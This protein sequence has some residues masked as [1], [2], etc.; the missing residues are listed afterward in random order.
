MFVGPVTRHDVRILRK[1]NF[2]CDLRLLG[3]TEFK[4]RMARD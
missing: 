4:L 2:V 3:R 1:E